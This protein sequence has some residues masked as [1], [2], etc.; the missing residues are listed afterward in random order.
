MTAGGGKVCA[1]ISGGE[2][3]PLTGI[4]HADFVIACD[5]GLEYASAAGVRP[6]LIIGDFDSYSGALPEGVPV[7]RLKAEKDDT[8]TMSAVRCAL[9]RGFSR[10][11]IYC[12]LGG[13]L[14]HLFANIQTMAFAVKGGA[15]AHII[16]GNEELFAFTGKTV[17]FPEREGWSLSV[18]AL[19]GRCGNVS[20]RG[21]KYCLENAVVESSFPIGTS[22][23]WL[24]GEIEISVGSGVILVMCC[25]MPQPS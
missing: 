13:R 18:F 1:I 15:D 22:N 5:K 6:D 16:G 21:A 9:E 8:D 7:T 17:T 23:Q 4:E 3:A 10:I 2:R 11:D 12:A 24:S 19:G 14:D 25:R 20:I